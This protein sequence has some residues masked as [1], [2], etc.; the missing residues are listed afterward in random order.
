MVFGDLQCYS[1]TEKSILLY[2]ADDTAGDLGSGVACRLGMKIVSHTVDYDR[3][4]NHICHPESVSGNTL[5][6]T[7]AAQ[8]QRRK[9]ACMGRVGEFG[10]IVMTAGAGIVTS[11][12]VTLVNMKAEEPE[13]ACRQ[14]FDVSGDHHAILLLV[15]FYLPTKGGVFS[16][17]V[18]DGIGPN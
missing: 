10:G 6:S 8:H 11:A 5:P 2:T 7:A 4:P 18:G 14:T 13:A 16:G 12:S 15:E 17:N 3:P 9:I 1:E